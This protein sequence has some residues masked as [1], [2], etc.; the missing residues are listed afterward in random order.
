MKSLRWRMAA[1]FVA[2]FLAVTAAFMFMSYRLLE[3]ELRQK[4]WQMDYPEHPDWRLHGSFSEAELRDIMTE[5]FE[6]ILLGAVPLLVATAVLGWWLARKSLHP[7]SSV[8]RQLKAKTPMNLGQPLQLPEADVEFRDLLVQLNELLKRLD[9]SF[10]EMNNYAARVAHELR[11]P[12]AIMRLKVEQAGSRIAPE[13]A[14]ELEHELHRLT[15]VV[16]QSLLLARAEQGR[17]TAQR[18][19][20]DLAAV[21]ADLVEDFALLAGE[22]RRRLRLVSPPS[23][24]VL[25]DTRHLRQI[26]HNLLSNALKHGQ[27]DFWV[28]VRR[29]PNHASLAVINRVEYCALDLDRSLG[30]GLRVVAVLLRLDPAVKIQRRRGLSYHAVRLSFPAIAPPA[31]SKES[32]PDAGPIPAAASDADESFFI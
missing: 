21:V 14:E 1:W 10:A 5:L 22:D 20:C 16:D 7:I 32:R 25:A 15:H 26:V 18:A 31:V 6:A 8:N 2:S 23:A 3:K 9:A 17:L 12:L 27:G 24:W 30:L 29:L 19:P 13:L 11:S 28:R 4:S